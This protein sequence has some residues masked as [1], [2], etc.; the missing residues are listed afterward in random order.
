M[1]VA[2]PSTI[3][4]LP[5]E[6]RDLINA[7]REQGRTLDEILTK[8][9]ELQV[10]GAETISRSALGRYTK[11]IDAAASEIRRSRAIAEALV[12]QYGEAPEGRTARLNI[13]LMHGLVLRQLLGGEDG[14]PVA[15]D[16]REAMFLGSALQKLAAAAKTDLEAAM[17]IRREMAAKAAEAVE[18]EAKARGLSRETVEAIKA[19]VMGVQS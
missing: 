12:K 6:V 7:L 2:R 19:R 3:R 14:E 9:R 11:E 18:Q 17:R 5:S 13:E 10:P 8:L 16:A 4:R 1:T 15:L